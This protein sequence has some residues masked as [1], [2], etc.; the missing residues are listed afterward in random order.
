MHTPEVQAQQAIDR[1][2]AGTIDADAL[3]AAFLQ[4][5]A[6]MPQTNR[7]G[8]PATDLWLTMSPP[9]SCPFCHNHAFLRGPRDDAFCICPNGRTAKRIEMEHPGIRRRPPPAP[10]HE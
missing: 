7:S 8:E 1:F 5:I 9:G 6:A 3:E 2:C 4:A 10:R